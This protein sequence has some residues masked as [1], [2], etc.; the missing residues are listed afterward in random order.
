MEFREIFLTP[1]RKRV[2]E[3]LLSNYKEVEDDYILPDGC[4]MWGYG[5][6]PLPIP[7]N[8]EPV[9]VSEVREMLSHIFPNF[10]CQKVLFAEDTKVVWFQR[11]GY[12]PG[13]KGRVGNE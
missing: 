7:T 4:V 11:K 12:K 10:E 13:K 6:H 1:E 9:T 3:T 2:R 8:D 5:D